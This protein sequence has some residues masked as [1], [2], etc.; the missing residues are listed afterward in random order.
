MSF[1]SNKGKL[2]LTL[3]LIP[4]LFSANASAGPKLELQ[5]REVVS[6]VQLRN[7]E[8]IQLARSRL[9]NERAGWNLSEENDFELIRADTDEYATTHIRFQQRFRGLRVFGAEVI[10]HVGPTDMFSPHTNATIPI[11]RADVTPHLDPDEAIDIALS[12]SGMEGGTLSQEPVAELLIFPIKKIE[13]AER[14]RNASKVDATM[15]EDKLIRN[16]LAYQV[17]LHASDPVKGYTSEVYIVDA[18]SGQLIK[19][20]SILNSAHTSASANTQHNG[21]VYINTNSTSTGYELRDVRRG[22]FGPGGQP[23]GQFGNNMVLGYNTAPPSASHVVTDSDNV[24]GDGSLYYTNAGQANFQTA[25]VDVA[26]AM[27]VAWDMYSRVLGRNGIDG[28]NFYSTFAIVHDPNITNNAYWFASCFCMKFGDGYSQLGQK[29]WTSVNIVGHEMAHGINESTAQLSGKDEAGGLNESNS[30]I[31]GTMTE[32]YKAAGAGSSTIP[33]IGGDWILLDEVDEFGTAQMP[34][35][36]PSLGIYQDEWTPDLIDQNRDFASA[37]MNRAFYFLSQGASQ[38]NVDNH[39]TPLLPFGMTGIGN[40]KAFRVW[41]RALSYYFTSTTDYKAARQALITAVRELY[42]PS[43]NEEKAVWNALHGINVGPAWVPAACGILRSEG[44]ISSGQNVYSCNGVYSL[45]MGTDGNLTH[46]QGASVLWGTNTSGNSGAYAVMQHDGN[47]AVYKY[48]TRPPY[49]LLWN[50]ATWDF[51]ESAIYVENGGNL[52]IRTVTGIPVWY[53][54]TPPEM[55]NIHT[56]TGGN[57]SASSADFITSSKAG[58]LGQMALAQHYYQFTLQPGQKISL[59]FVAARLT[60]TDEVGNSDYWD[61][62]ILDSNQN[63]LATSRTNSLAY[64]ITP[65]YTN[66]TAAGQSILIRVNRNQPFSG[67]DSRV[68]RYSLAISYQ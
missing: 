41:Y 11:S 25:A 48:Q 34:M 26:Y 40:D 17:E 24:W 35:Y 9:H 47:L 43:S 15:M 56:G 18:K 53:R 64:R 12:I 16:A 49:S 46:K 67:S 39:Y 55:A 1:S 45:E 58:I 22:N 54:T 13:V 19:R 38:W 31:F 65:T 32:F 33:E 50:S 60:G 10:T 6:S 21:T 42:G 29:S 68:K 51:P 20:W 8:R 37:P 52:V 23:K 27:G 30:D 62:S 57:T 59:D 7:D 61:V 66:T 63:V 36:K 3:N 14:F 28:V 5:A 4:L 2:A 44:T